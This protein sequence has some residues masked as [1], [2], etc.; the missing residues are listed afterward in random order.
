MPIEGDSVTPLGKSAFI[1]FG[2]D[3]ISNKWL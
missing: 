3:A 2:N 1:R